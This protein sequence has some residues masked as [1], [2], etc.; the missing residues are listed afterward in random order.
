MS[1]TLSEIQALTIDVWMPGAAPNWQ[2]GNI[3]MYKLIQNADPK[4]SGEQVR[5]PLIYARSNGGAFG[6]TTIFNTTKKATHNAARFPWAYFYGNETWDIED[7]VKVNGGES[8]VDLLMSKLDNMQSSIKDYMGDSIWT[9]YATAVATY[10]AGTIPFYGIADLFAASSAYGG[11]A[12]A[13]LGTFT[14]AGT[15]SSQNIWAPYSSSDSLSMTFKTLQL[16]SRCTR[17]GSDN[18]KQVIDMIVTTATLKDAFEAQIQSQQRHYD[19]DLG[20]AGF[21]H[22]NFRT[23]CPVVVDDKSTA[24]YV[25]GFNMKNFKLHPHQ[26]FNFTSPEWRVPVNQPQIKTCSIMFAG[27]IGTGA[28]RSHG[29]LT[30]VS[31]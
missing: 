7:D 31:A 3:M 13:D 2:M 16:L 30:S 17:V 11:I 23:G 27:A 28:R 10:G 26:E 9:A 4:P 25:Q 12:A 8:G 20:K 19:A 22:V 15:G 14:N 21:D 5:Y 29:Q 24:N 1:L 18:G 6:P